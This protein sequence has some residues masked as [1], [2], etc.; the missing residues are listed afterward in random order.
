MSNRTTSRTGKVGVVLA[1]VLVIGLFLGVAPAFASATSTAFVNAH[2]VL[3]GQSGKAFTI[4]VNNTEAASPIQQLAGKTIN[5]VRIRG[6]VDLIDAVLPGSA[7]P[8]AFSDIQLIGSPPAEIRFYAPSG[9]LAPGSNATFTVLADVRNT[10]SQD[11]NDVWRVRT[12]S[13]GGQAHLA[14]GQTGEG[15]LTN[16]RVLDVQSVAILGPTGAAD[17]RDGDGK[18]EVTGT[19]GNIC[20]RSRIANAGNAA[21]NVTP[22]LTAN[23]TTVGNPRAAATP[24]CSGAE[25]PGGAGSIAARGTRD[26]DFLISAADVGSVTASELVGT[27][28]AGNSSTP[29]SSDPDD[30]VLI[31]KQALTIEPRANLSYVTNSLAPRA[32]RP[33]R[34]G[35]VSKANFSLRINKGPNGSPP[36]TTVAGNFA[37][38]FCNAPATGPTSLDGGAQNNQNVTF[39]ECTIADIPDGRY[40]PAVNFGY[41]DANGLVRAPS[42]MSGLEKIRLDSLIPDV[43]V[44]ITPPPVQVTA[45][46]PVEPAVT[47]GQNFSASGTVTDTSP[48][49]GEDTPCGPNPGG[50]TAPL[51]CTLVSSTL[52]QYSDTA[53][54]GGGAQ[55]PARKNVPCTLSSSGNLSCTINVTFDPGTFSTS[56]EICVKD[57]TENTVCALSPL[58]D[59]DIIKPFI[60]TAT[61]ARGGTVSVG[62]QQVP[63]QRRTIVVQFNEPVET[64]SQSPQDWT[65]QDGSTVAICGVTQSADKRTVTLTTCQELHA[66]TTGTLTYAPRP[67]V[68]D[69]YHD[70]VGQDTAAPVEKSLLDGIAPLAPTFDTVENKELQEDAPSND[71]FFFN[72][73]TPSAHLIQEAPASAEDPAIANGYTVEVYEETDGTAGLNRLTDRQVCGDV[74][75]ADN[76]TVG[77][78]FTG[79]DRTSKVYAISIDLNANVGAAISTDW[80]LDRVR[81][82]I[83]SVV[84]SS[85]PSDITVNFSERVPRGSDES[86]NFTY[87]AE[88]PNGEGRTSPDV[89]SVGSGATNESRVVGYA[90][91]PYAPSTL[92]P[93]E[94]R[95]HFV[96]TAP[97]ALRYEDR[98]GNVLLD[99]NFLL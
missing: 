72:T 5:E 38:P 63:G 93:D 44:S 89:E 91:S 67:V 13:T 83:G 23:N 70:R 62:N 74:A 68:G 66:D 21:L 37:S 77:C 11:R 80:V 20:V 24:P 59:V 31:A 78:D 32:V 56:L 9:G 95:Y 3:A 79:I 46:P 2:N 8:T 97:G 22:G 19:Q 42:A 43:N 18:P 84:V 55:L 6:P 17:D 10:I 27:A 86:G 36:L 58:V 61:T 65:V 7:G 82:V 41:T 87:I 16:V 26:F 15:L 57:E 54:N 69:P 88:R 25:L 76:V 85:N 30:D 39:A 33:S 60:N 96:Q 51:P 81:P 45:V 92:T 75:T 99:I 98:A 71:K 50:S 4:R 73:T 12:S 35:F 14:S 52:I 90:D 64:A 49:T 47:S 53:Q 34:P 1:L 29:S 28:T 40:D 48:E 94:F